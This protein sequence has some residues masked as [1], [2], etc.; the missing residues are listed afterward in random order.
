MLGVLP[1]VAAFVDDA[2]P[3]AL[4]T[5]VATSSAPIHAPSHAKR[6]LELPMLF[7]LCT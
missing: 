2:V 1:A 7:P 5:A 4:M 6:F 3:A